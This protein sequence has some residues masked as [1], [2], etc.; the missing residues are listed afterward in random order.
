MT[1]EIKDG[2]FSGKDIVVKY[3]I[4][5]YYEAP[6]QI[7]MT[8]MTDDH[9]RR[10]SGAVDG[11]TITIVPRQFND[12]YG[13][14]MVV[15]NPIYKE[16]AVRIIY[17][18]KI[19]GEPCFRLRNDNFVLHDAF[20]KRTIGLYS[21]AIEAKIAAELG[22]HSI[23]ARAA[24]FPNTPNK[25]GWWAW[26][27]MGYDAALKAGIKA[28]LPIMHRGAKTLNDLFASQ[29][30]RDVWSKHG[31]PIEVCFDLRNKSTSWQILEKYMLEKGCVL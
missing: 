8:K 28:K 14:A 22:F 4:D 9:W 29:E 21:F 7:G 26:P 19:S 27:R 31:Q 1:A 17:M 12:V 23:T 5:G 3:Q 24:G 18:E 30:G 11:S 15:E 25:T 16:N 13:I 2:F 20:Q 10:L 6:V